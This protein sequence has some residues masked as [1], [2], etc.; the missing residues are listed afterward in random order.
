MYQQE[1]GECMQNQIQRTLD[2]G[3]QNTKVDQN[4]LLHSPKRTFAVSVT[5][6]CCRASVP[7]T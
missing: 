5:H 2:L 3:R 1:L 4:S 7:G 6:L